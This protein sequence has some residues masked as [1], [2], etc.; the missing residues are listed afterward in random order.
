MFFWSFGKLRYILTGISNSEESRKKVRL[1]ISKS[2][3]TRKREKTVG[4]KRLWEMR[5]RLLEI[6]PLGLS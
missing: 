6:N 5:H 2:Q 1:S 4:E 3:I